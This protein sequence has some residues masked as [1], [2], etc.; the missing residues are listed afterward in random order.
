MI[1][2]PDIDLQKFKSLFKRYKD[3]PHNE[4]FAHFR[5]DSKK[6]ET[7][8][9]PFERLAN[10]TKEEEWSFSQTQFQS[11]YAN[12]KYPILTNYL[13][14]TFLRLIEQNKIKFIDNE[15]A[16]FNTGLQTPQEKDIYVTFTLNEKAEEYKAP[17]FTLY[18]FFD[19]YSDK[20]SDFHP[21]P[22]LASYI[23]DP[24]DLIFDTRL[25][26]DINLEH[27]I[28]ENRHRLPFDLQTNDRLAQVAIKGAMES[29][30]SRIIRN[31]KI[32]IPNWYNGKLQ[33]LLPLHLTNDRVPDLALVVDRDKVANIYRARTVL[34][35][36]LAY[37]DARLITRP[38]RQ[39]LNP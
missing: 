11:K 21:L 27:I 35:M 23:E 17:P 33:L 2:K 10:M 8:E 34:T 15:K 16:C 18:N 4:V 39:W 12:Q 13:N 24:A 5:Y 38:D 22:E 3:Q 1:T 30:R 32:A 26:I 37:I 7:W 31:Y 25:D 6:G 29:L 20:L 14:Y 28:N 36:D 19:S 9:T